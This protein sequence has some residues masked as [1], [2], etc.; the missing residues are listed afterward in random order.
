MFREVMVNAGLCSQRI[1]HT[2]I[3]MGEQGMTLCMEVLQCGLDLGNEGLVLAGTLSWFTV[4]CSSEVRVR[5]CTRAAITS[6][7]LR[8]KGTT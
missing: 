7:C 5:A 3:S 2:I 4:N 8:R 1:S 6:C